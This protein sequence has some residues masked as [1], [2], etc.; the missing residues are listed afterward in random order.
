MI[1]RQKEF[2]GTEIT[3]EIFNVTIIE[4]TLQA[5]SGADGGV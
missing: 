4:D 5:N 3:E 2:D 1:P